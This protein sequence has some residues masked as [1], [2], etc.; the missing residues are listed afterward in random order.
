M[1]QFPLSLIPG[2]CCTSQRVTYAPQDLFLVM[3][4]GISEVPNITVSRSGSDV[5][6]A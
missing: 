4:D 5:Q 6:I 2:G 3:T 1:E